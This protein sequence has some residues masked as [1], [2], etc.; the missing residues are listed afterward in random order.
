MITQVGLWL[1]GGAMVLL[2]ARRAS[3][4]R[5]WEMVVGALLPALLLLACLGSGRDLGDFRLRLEGVLVERD[6][7]AGAFSIGGSA[8]EDDI[9]FAGL[10]DRAAQLRRGDD[11][12]PRWLLGIGAGESDDRLSVVELQPRNGERRIA[13]S[14]ALGPGDVIC[15]DR[16]GQRGALALRLRADGRGLERLDGGE[17]LPEFRTHTY[18]VVGLFW[19]PS[20]A[21]YPLRDYGVPWRGASESALEPCWGRFLC[22]GSP[23]VPVRSFVYRA[24]GAGDGC[25]RIVLLDPGSRLIRNGRVIG[26]AE[27]A[28]VPLDRSIERL[29]FYSISYGSPYADLLDGDRPSSRLTLRGAVAP[30]ATGR[31]IDLAI[32]GGRS[33]PIERRAI[34]EARD[35]APDGVSITLVGGSEASNE[36]IENPLAIDLLG[37]ETGRALGHRLRF[38][39]SDEFGRTGS[40]FI[41]SGNEEPVRLGRSFVAGSAEPLRAARLRLERLDRPFALILVMPFVWAALLI[42]AQARTWRENRLA[43]LLGVAMQWLLAFRVLIG[44]ESAMLD[45]ELSFGHAMGGNIAAYVAL[46]MALA[47]VTPAPAGPRESLWPATLFAASVVLLCTWLYGSGAAMA[48]SWLGV[49][50]AA[51]VATWDPARSLVAG[52][53]PVRIVAGLSKGR[54]RTERFAARIRDFFSTTWWAWPALIVAIAAIRL[55]LVA[56][57]I[58][59]RFTWPERFAVSIVYVPM[60]LLA[61]A[62][63]FSTAIRTPPRE[64]VKWSAYLGTLGLSLGLVPFIVGDYGLFIYAIPV[65]AL[66][67]AVT[68]Q[69]RPG[70]FHTLAWNAVPAAAA[71][72]IAL[73]IVYGQLDS[74]SWEAEVTTVAEEARYARDRETADAAHARAAALLADATEDDRNWLRLWTAFAPERVARSGTSAAESQRRV[75]AIL[76]D[77]TST[78]SGRG[79]LARSDPADIRPYQADD[80]LSAVHLMSPF[81]RVGAAVLVMMIGVLAWRTSPL[82]ARGDVASLAGTLATWTL[83][84]TA[85]YM[86]LAN[87]QLVPFTGRNIYLLAAL[88]ASDLLEGWILFAMAAHATAG[89]R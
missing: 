33:Y 21:I 11:G 29:A 63:L 56:A 54:V 49:L 64:W 88:S 28:R 12:A 20:Q 84:A 19:P 48:V 9:V 10:P 8:E 5:E 59:E 62:G 2:I 78:L 45:P 47:A 68:R 40:S 74:R 30:A 18:A 67:F 51:A 16:C 32:V 44:T 36:S 26:R 80:N 82:V 77:Y 89:V 53:G 69:R 39:E 79:Y 23:P 41:L 43:F 7:L 55:A 52:K 24:C 57:G 66:A 61:F 58:R 46:P 71:S 70:R 75:S 1:T 72:L 17:L 34:D 22:R 85:A 13:G 81:G 76:S 60:L 27:A 15:L 25:L 4:T 14:E 38:D 87:L 83:F 3:T 50:F 37:G 42:A 6:T 73:S 65:A 31:A 35:S 86:V